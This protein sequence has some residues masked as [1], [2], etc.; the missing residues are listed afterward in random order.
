MVRETALLPASVPRSFRSRVQ[1]VHLRELWPY[2]LSGGGLIFLAV[3]VGRE[4]GELLRTIEVLRSARMSWLALAVIAGIGMQ[5]STMHA[6]QSM[7]RRWGHRVPFRVLAGA[8]LQ[9][10][11]VS[12]IT[13][14]GGIAGTWAFVRNL[15][16][17][18]VN[19]GD[20]LSV[21]ILNSVLGYV[22][23]AIYLIPVITLSTL[24]GATSWAITLL[25]VVFGILTVAF[26]GVL[27]AVINPSGTIAGRRLPAPGRVRALVDQVREH[28]LEANDL[29]RPLAW[30]VAVEGFGVLLLWAALQAV[31]GHA[32]V[33]VAA[34]GY[35]VGTLFQLVAPLFAG[36]GAVELSMTVALTQ[37][38]I[39]AGVALAAVLLFRSVEVWLPLLAGVSSHIGA[40]SEVRR[41]TMRLPAIF[42]G[43]TGALAIVFAITPRITHSLNR[44]EDYSRVHPEDF[45]R[46]VLLIAGLLLIF[47]SSNLWR[48]KR[49]AWIASIALLSFLIVVSMLRWHDAVLVAIATV[50]LALLVVQ[51][52]R[53]RV[54][55]DVP[56]MR[57][58]VI[59]LVASLIVAVGYGAL[60][61]FLIDKRAFGIDFSPFEA[62]ESTLRLYF[63]L[64]G[65]DLTA[66]T[67]SGQWFLDSLQLVGIASLG[68]ALV[69]LA[70][71]VVWRQ[72]VYPR[73]R[74]RAREMIEEFGD[75]SLDFFKYADDK[76]FF[77]ASHGRGV[78]SYGYAR[79]CAVALGD[80]TAATDEDFELV[81]AEFL[82][83]CDTNG[84]RVAFHQ[85]GPHRQPVY[86]AHG[87]QSVKVGE[88]AV[89]DLDSFTLAGG[90]MKNIRSQ[91]HK[92]EREGYRVVSY[93]APQT[94]ER[95]AGLRAV[96]DEW[97]QLGGHR[98][99][100]FTLGQFEDEYIRHST[101]FTVERADGE[102]VAF[103]NLIP[104]GVE[105]ETTLDLMRRKAEPAGVMDLLFVRVM[106]QLKDAGYRRFS[107][108]MAPFAN[109]GVD[110]DARLTE[111]LI[112]QLYEHFNRLF[113]FKGLHT[114]KD[115]FHPRWEPRYLV[116]RSET[117]LPL[118]VLAILALTE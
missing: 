35:A 54:R 27:L 7:L 1:R 114:Y 110:H 22:S 75:S 41:G 24:F 78:V 111:R 102:I 82:E 8:V 101:V 58:G 116:Y 88:D 115:K 12:V 93:P 72:T 74:Q 81:L 91:V 87:L 17:R 16:R 57:H 83:F 55:S 45:S 92:L 23:F 98:E 79:G 71:P 106:E 95:L 97:L 60:G 13:P 10:E 104:D 33:Q 52:D 86:R 29:A 9:R 118:I 63:N 26:L 108:G 34:V 36:I 53:F 62:V 56:T 39:P 46:H 66:R 103:T 77:V 19:T 38:G 37:T 40:R 15:D 113:S 67:R 2:L 85:S 25:A 69:S 21:A 43:L 109:V 32:N 61:F 112:H 100:R 65:G 44:V 30:H 48:R 96:S 84:W 107:M 3:F 64:D 42:T 99:R 50:N 5:V 51:R 73:E 90:A 14:L 70:R 59:A 47:M 76:L 20:A 68:F 105:G 4:R 49:V 11:A 6:Y 89:V 117:S 18:G 80:P 28:G 31:H 94:D